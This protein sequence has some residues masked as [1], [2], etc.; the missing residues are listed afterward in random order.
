MIVTPDSIRYSLGSIVQDILDSLR[1]QQG[2]ANVAGPGF[3]VGNRHDGIVVGSGVEVDK[4]PSRV[5]LEVSHLPVIDH[6]VTR[7]LL[8]KLSRIQGEDDEYDNK[9]L[10]LYSGSMTAKARQDL[11]GSNVVA[12]SLRSREDL[13]SQF[14]TTILPNYKD[15]GLSD[16]S[17]ELLVALRDVPSGSEHSSLYEGV[18]ESILEFLFYPELG[19]PKPQSYTLNRS[20]R[21]DFIMKNEAQDGFWAR[22]RERYKADYLIVEVKNVRGRVGNGSVWQLAGYMKEKGVGFFGMLIA[23]MEPR[24]VPPILPSLISGCTPTR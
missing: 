17:Q 22:A 10:L 18:C 24:V 6:T 16:R 9:F 1:G 12:R 4:L 14:W 15:P 20:Q 8:K 19:P 11:D 5:F 13:K 7:E 23:E 21:R 2:V 3:L